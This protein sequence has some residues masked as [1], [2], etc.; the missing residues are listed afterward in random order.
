MDVRVKWTGM[1]FAV[2]TEGGRGDRGLRTGNKCAAKGLQQHSGG[3]G[4]GVGRAGRERVK[5]FL[6]YLLSLCIFFLTSCPVRHN[7]SQRLTC[8]HNK[9]SRKG[10]VLQMSTDEPHLRPR[11]SPRTQCI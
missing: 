4:G 10:P 2:G 7:K 11:Q 5:R 3:I 8:T 9:T 6:F 1:V